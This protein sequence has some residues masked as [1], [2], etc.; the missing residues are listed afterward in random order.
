[1]PHTEKDLPK[2]NVP[3]KYQPYKDVSLDRNKPE[4][5][6]DIRGYCMGANWQSK[7][8]KQCP[9]KKLEQKVESLGN[10]TGKY[11]DELKNHTHDKFYEMLVKSNEEIAKLK[12]RVADI[13]KAIKDSQVAFH[14]SYHETIN[15]RIKNIC[16][17]LGMKLNATESPSIAEMKKFS[18]TLYDMVEGLR[19]KFS[20]PQVE[21]M[22]EV[23]KKRLGENERVVDAIPSIESIKKKPIALAEIDSL[24]LTI[25]ELKTLP[26]FY[27]SHVERKKMFEARFDDRNFEVGDYLL[28]KEWD[29]K[30]YTGRENTCEITYILRADGSFFSFLGKY[31]ILGIRF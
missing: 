18:A 4:P 9:L 10:Q 5:E 14:M 31:V 2:L 26:E 13:E 20:K 25:H 23:E 28:L 24:N 19:N 22:R 29:G 16:N 30:K 11:L 17:A 12:E 27:Q 1:M 3:K 6:E 7:C 8:H 21:N 15:K